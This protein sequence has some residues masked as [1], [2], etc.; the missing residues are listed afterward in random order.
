MEAMK[1]FTKFMMVL[2][3]YTKECLQCVSERHSLLDTAFPVLLLDRMQR[4]TMLLSSLRKVLRRE[5][6]VTACQGP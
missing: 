6:I 3:M 1:P 5:A 2:K 4:P